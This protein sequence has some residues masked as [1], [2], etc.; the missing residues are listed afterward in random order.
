MF[1]TKHTKEKC[2]VYLDDIIVFSV[3]LREHINNLK[4][5]FQRLRKTKFKIQ[6]DKSEYMRKEIAYLGHVFTP[7]GTKPNLDKGKR[8]QTFP[9]SKTTKQIK[10]FHGLLEN[11]SKFINN[12]AKLT[13]LFTKCLKKVL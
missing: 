5:V 4:S 1:F 2:V 3:Y 10:A 7:N 13:K 6:L 11:C 8:I 12:F 9:I